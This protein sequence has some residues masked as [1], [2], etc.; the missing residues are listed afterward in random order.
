MGNCYCFHESLVMCHREFIVVWFG[1]RIFDQY[2]YIFVIHNFYAIWSFFILSSFIIISRWSLY[3]ILSL[4]WQRNCSQLINEYNKQNPVMS[5][6]P[7]IE[8]VYVLKFLQ[9]TTSNRYTY[10]TIQYAFRATT[11]CGKLI[12]MY[13]RIEMILSVCR[14]QWLLGKLQCMASYR[15]HCNRSPKNAQIYNC[16]LFEITTEGDTKEKKKYESEMKERRQ[17]FLFSVFRFS[18]LFLVS[19]HLSLSLFSWSIS[20]FLSSAPKSNKVIL[21]AEY[22]RIKQKSTSHERGKRKIL[23]AKKK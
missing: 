17:S 20:K 1:Q 3:Y 9:Y 7:R 16:S 19:L 15:C 4:L 2:I 18:I 5:S 6:I 11:T 22:W 21:H 8:W 14:S 13:N 23:H 10:S 12:E